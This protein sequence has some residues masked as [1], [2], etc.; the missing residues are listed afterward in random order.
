MRRFFIVMLAVFAL[1]AGASLVLAQD[2]L[3]QTFTA[4]DG[5]LSF[6]YPDGWTAQGIPQDGVT[7]VLLSPSGGNILSV[8][9]YG[10]ANSIFNTSSMAFAPSTDGAVISTVQINGKDATRLELDKGATAIEYIVTFDNGNKLVVM[11]AVVDPQGVSAMDADLMAIAASTVEGS[12]A[13]VVAGDPSAQANAAPVDLSSVQPITVANAAQVAN[14]TMLNAGTED[15]VGAIAFS[16]D[17]KTLAVGV[18][19]VIKL[20]DVATNTVL[21]TL[22]GH[23]DSI[24]S[25]AYSPD[26]TMLVSGS[27]DQTVRIWDVATGESL[28]NIAVD[29]GYPRSRVIF[30]PD[31]KT[32]AQ[33]NFGPLRMW[34]VATGNEITTIQATGGDVGVNFS[35]FSPDGTLLATA[36]G[37]H[38]VQ[39]WD[40]ASG[41]LVA[42]LNGHVASVVAVAFSP[43]GK[44]LA[45]G[46][47]DKLVDLWDV[48]TH[49]ILQDLEGNVNP[50]SSVAFSPDGSVIASASRDVRLWNV[51]TG[52]VLATLPSLIGFS[53]VAFSPDGKLLAFSNADD[54]IELWGTASAS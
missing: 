32:I 47:D 4:D 28:K 46:A 34:D 3:T 5:S 9:S 12:G 18:G 49:H 37:D 31:G 26:G 15:L 44:I 53:N 8:V 21:T 33:S 7:I 20:I 39:L 25:V 42:S 43:D 27:Q 2:A 10:P 41:S 1:I 24:L 11:G 48:E 36:G 14:I 40:V 45:S 6:Q 30:S 52:E 22:E 23:A 16:P 35:A 51:A 29:S 54:A 17:G 13:N 38:I 50:V 19:K